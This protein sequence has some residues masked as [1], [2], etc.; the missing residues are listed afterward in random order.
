MNDTKRR[1]PTISPTQLRSAECLLRWGQDYLGGVKAQLEKSDAL[2]F[3]SK[4]DTEFN[5]YYL[6][7]KKPGARLQAVLQHLPAP[8]DGMQIQ[9]KL[10]LDLGCVVM[11]GMADGLTADTLHDFKTSREPWKWA[12]DEDTLPLDE[13]AIIYGLASGR[14]LL[15]WTYAA[16]KGD[17]KN[18]LVVRSRLN[19]ASL[20][21]FRSE[22]LPRAVVLTWLWSQ[23]GRINPLSLPGNAAVCHQFGGCDY[24]DTCNER[25]KPGSPW[26]GI[27][28]GEK[29]MSILQQAL[30]QMGVPVANGQVQMP[31]PMPATPTTAAVGQPAVP[32]ANA[33]PPNVQPAYH[34]ALLTWAQQNNTTTREAYRQVTAQ[35]NGILGAGQLVDPNGFN[36]PEAFY[37]GQVANPTPA[38]LAAPVSVNV[39][40]AAPAVAQTVPAATAPQTVPTPTASTPATGTKLAKAQVA[41]RDA[42][43][44]G[45]VTRASAMMTDDELRTLADYADRATRILG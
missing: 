43:Y 44:V 33:Q 34:Q 13:Q 27:E 6:H 3:G 25:F 18:G 31:L 41:T 17:P 22:L 30:G 8:T 40:A 38:T 16:S 19:Q 23:H 24:K 5:D 26:L 7:G 45:L 1:L 28:Y 35:S 4:L 2:Q 14:E 20:D 10:R 9:V 42:I 29:Y 32:D 37:A 39:P 15:Q 36:M 12:H 21:R 11:G